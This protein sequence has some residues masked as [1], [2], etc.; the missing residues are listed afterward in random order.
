MPPLREKIICRH[1]LIERLSQGKNRPLITITGEAGSGKTSLACQWIL[2]DKLAVAWYSLDETDNDADIFF[3]YLFAGLA[4]TDDRLNAALV[5]WIQDERTLTGKDVILY[6]VE[7]LM[8]LP[9]EIYLV[10]DDY[11]FVSRREIHEAMSGLLNHLPENL[12]III[13]SR[14]SIPFNISHFKI[15]NRM[16]EI[17]PSD[18]K[19]TE[20]E[21]EQFVT[22]MIPGRL[23]PDEL[24]ELIR[25]AEGW[26]GGLQLFGLSIRE[27]DFSEDFGNIFAKLNQEA[28]DYLSNEVITVQPEKIRDF[29][30]R[31]VLLDRFNAHVAR[32]ITGISDA[33]D[34][35]EQVYRNNLFLIPLDAERTWYRYHHLFSDAVRKKVKSTFPDIFSTVHRQAALWFAANN[36]LEDAFRSAFA[37]EDYEFMADLMESRLLFIYEQDDFSFGLRWLSK[38]PHDISINRPLLRLH[39]CGKKMETFQ[40]ED[41]EAVIKDIENHQEEM[42]ERYEGRQKTLCM[43][44]FI[45]MKSILYHY[46]KNP[47]NANIDE[48]NKVCRMISTENR[49]FSGYIKILITFGHLAKGNP[50]LAESTLQEASEIIFTTTTKNLLAKMLCFR[51]AATVERMRGRLHRSADMLN[52]GFQFLEQNA[53]AGRPLK[54]QLYIPSAWLCYHRGELDRAVEYAAE[55]LEYVSRVNYVRDTVECNLILFLVHIARNEAE[56]A[57]GYIKTMSRIAKGINAPDI[58]IPTDPWWMRLYLLRGDIQSCQSWMEQRRFSMDEPFSY[59]FVYECLIRARIFHLRK[60][61]RDAAQML[62]KLRDVCVENDLHEIIIDI[63]LALCVTLYASHDFER[64]RKTM[65]QVLSF[66]ESEEF[67]RPFADYAA[68]L[69]PAL[70]DSRWMPPGSH[71]PA[72]IRPILSA[73]RI[74]IKNAARSGKEKKE[75]T[76]R[77]VEILSLMALGYQYKEIASKTFISDETVKTHAKN[78][79]KKLGVNTRLQA[80]RRAED[81]QLL[82][83]RR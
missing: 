25:Y 83:T 60:R 40:L 32:E 64:A 74:D 13:I 38:L 77:E 35:L 43:D 27:K 78:I 68:D 49:L 52:R 55:A 18:M 23:S 61:Y 69:L 50:L 24:H 11:H 62:G 51:L 80:I 46:F 57:Q 41:V 8:A 76:V 47:A 37:S 53:L 48:L 29:I 45:Y 65:E 10:L 39:T 66:A 63:D 36:C 26:V 30:Y 70:S 3:R 67:I 15:R 42:F 33:A 22:E 72:R 6:L 82:K 9:K 1:H 34:V 20:K 56:A 4:S 21:T 28:A 79:Y 58:G 16:V 73:C 81:L 2:R 14:Y 19:L 59:R 71:L 7:N 12:H 44:S 54:F 5:S 75:L 31:T 17:S